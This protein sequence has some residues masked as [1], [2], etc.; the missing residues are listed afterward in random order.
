[1]Y[2]PACGT[3]NR[4]ER[5]FCSACG[6]ALNVA[7]G[8]SHGA[9]CSICGFENEP[10]ESYCGGCGGTLAATGTL[11]PTAEAV[12]PEAERRQLTILFCDLVG[13]TRMSTELD[14]EDYRDIIR[15]YQNACTEAIE[16][17]GGFIARYMGD[18]IVAYFGYPHADEYD[19]ERAIR[20]GLDIV[21]RVTALELLP[22]AARARALHVRVGMATGRV[23]VGDLIGSTR[24][25]LEQA[26]AGETPNL[27]ARI[28]GE[29]EPDTVLV[30]PST[31]RLAG[32]AFRYLDLGPRRLKGIP[33]PVNLWQVVGEETFDR[34][35][36]WLRR[37]DLVTFVGRDEEVE[38]L[39]G[40]WQQAQR[41]EGQVVL[42][43][44][45]PG[46]G[47]SRVVKALRARLA[48]E[49]C[50]ELQVQ[51]SPH[52]RSSA[53]YPVTRQ[54]ALTAGFDPEDDEPTRLG[55]LERLLSDWGDRGLAS[56]PWIAELLSIPTAG[57]YPPIDLPPQRRR[58]QVLSTLVDLFKGLCTRQTVLLVL[59]DAHWIDPTT[60]ELAGRLVE[61]VQETR[62]LL[63]ITFRPEFEPPWD[64]HAH[65]T[66]L[67]LNRLDYSECLHLVRRLAGEPALPP[68]LIEHI[69]ER[70]DGV[71]LF[72][73][74]LTRTV[75]ESD[76]VRLNG[77]HYELTGPL[78]QLDIPETLQAS[79]LARLDR[80][81]NVKETAQV[82][83]T[84]GREFSAELLG[85]VS[86]LESGELSQQLE[87]LVASGLVY[88]RSRGASTRYA[89][90]HALVRDA[91]YD[92]LL[93]RRRRRL[94]AR[95]V[96]VVENRVT[97]LPRVPPELLAYHCHEA[98]MVE[99]AVAYCLDAGQQASQRSANLE[100]TAHL[101]QGLK[102]LTELDDEIERKR[103]E[104][105]L[106]IALGPPLISIRGPGTR[107]V[108]EDYRRA[109]TLCESLPGSP[110]H[111]DAHWG[112]WRVA[113]NFHLRRK[114]A[115]R[116]QTLADRLGEPGYQLEAH[117]CQWASLYHLG[118]HD[119][120]CRHVEQGLALYG[121]HAHRGH[122][123]MYGGHDARVCG[124]GEVALSKWLL[125]QP[126][127]S[128]E[129]LAKSLAW[130]EDLQHAGSEAHARFFELTLDLY[131]RDPAIAG[132]RAEALVE[133]CTEHGLPD[134]AANGR[135][136]RGWSRAELGDPVAGIAEMRDA[137]AELS[138]T[139]TQEDLP[140]C[141]STLAEIY[142][143]TGRYDEGL[144]Q[145]AA[146]LSMS[147]GAG[148]A[149]WTAELHR[150]RGA[151]LHATGELDRAASEFHRALELASRQ[152]ARFF[153]LRAL[154]GL[155]RLDGLDVGESRVRLGNLLDLYADLPDLPDVIA[156]RVAL[157]AP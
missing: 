122:A 78:T 135:F 109:L 129:N 37:E 15:A 119:G 14:P 92:S 100:A 48:S 152:K 90:K 132:G 114:R 123:W 21:Q 137:I 125:G 81:G 26:V 133:F 147:D 71:P 102:Y 19:P 105:K 76:V 113:T 69:I 18:G 53:L 136:F 111:F 54:L 106:R 83:A 50:T 77:D 155:V 34:R 146:A 151:L 108:E 2:C 98:G 86:E 131:R 23:V 128:R 79:L 144:E 118:D 63:L 24:V 73:E 6:T 145:L 153:E 88:R 35:S 3:W 85:A 104:L 134:Y 66:G 39:Y 95:L 107:E 43:G 91:A 72:V 27:A 8:A 55:K 150:C 87:R 140:W 40:L 44:G 142:L 59:E 112:W 56:V 12:A 7:G 20:A 82:A 99:K 41:S 124:H 115:Q 121:E 10:G 130:S 28:Q 154:T 47:K 148:L 52:F 75:L 9:T 49:P 84:I 110:E 116:L 42:L 138:V 4:D 61:V 127:A 97:P 57:R 67:T 74:E 94:H 89:F 30:A 58:E 101:E 38:Q 149:Y 70:T 143:N 13:S 17:R 120:C 68:Q 139:G 22:D 93:R 156:A 31:H 64:T 25:S 62:G 45:E 96:S 1:M 51:C 33:A 29:A 16:G 36:G 141:L 11:A 65:V 5:R 60:Q 46:I 80:L 157:S 103:W 32:R 126:I 117:H